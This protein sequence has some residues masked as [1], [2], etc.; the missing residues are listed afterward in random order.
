MSIASADTQEEE[1]FGAAVQIVTE[2]LQNAI[3]NENTSEACENVASG[4]FC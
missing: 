2:K 1:V 4:V 3:T